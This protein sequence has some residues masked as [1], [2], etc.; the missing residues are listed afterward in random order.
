[1]LVAHVP[2]NTQALV[3]ALAVVAAAALLRLWLAVPKSRVFL[4]DFA[5]HKSLEEWRFS[6][7]LF[8]PLSRKTGVSCASPLLQMG[9]LVFGAQGPAHSSSSSS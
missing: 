3:V 4:V 1:L 6:K 7:D 2:N 8:I 5:V 9:A